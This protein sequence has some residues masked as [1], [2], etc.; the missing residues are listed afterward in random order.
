MRWDEIMYRGGQWAVV[1]GK[2]ECAQAEIKKE[3]HF[4]GGMQREKD[5]RRT[6]NESD[7]DDDGAPLVRS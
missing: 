7:W 2:E 4:A 5:R 3:L 1:P 6:E